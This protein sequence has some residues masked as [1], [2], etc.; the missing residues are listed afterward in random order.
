[1]NPKL[2]LRT[3]SAISVMKFSKMNKN[4]CMLKKNFFI[5]CLASD[6]TPG[7]ILSSNREKGINVSSEVLG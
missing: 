3:N 1:M 4:L 2:E 5:L 6:L 7:C